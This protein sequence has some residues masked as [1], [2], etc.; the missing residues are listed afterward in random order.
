MVTLKTVMA[1]IRLTRMILRLKAQNMKLK[2][3]Q[4]RSLQ[5]RSQR[6]DLKGYTTIL[7]HNPRTIHS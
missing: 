6:L 7:G 5:L 1:L 3:L 4:L 2:S